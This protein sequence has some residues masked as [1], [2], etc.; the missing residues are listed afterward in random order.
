[1]P[2]LLFLYAGDRLLRKIMIDNLLG[3]SERAADTAGRVIEGRLT[4]ARSAVESLAADPVT[5]DAW[6]H[7]DIQRLTARL[8]EAH[9]HDLERQVTF[10]GI[11][12]SKGFL[13]SG[14]PPSGADLGGNFASYDWFTGTTQTRTVHVSTGSPSVN[15]P[16][17]FVIIV[18]APL[19]CG[20][21][22]CWQQPTLPR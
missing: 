14:Y 8:R 16:K 9:D 13:R 17:E 19:G 1:L 22:V 5:V 20:Q 7:R 3:Q 11:Y 12:D 4:D 10:W 2:L 15:V 18:A 21:C 6:M